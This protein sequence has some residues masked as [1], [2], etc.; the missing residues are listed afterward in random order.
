MHNQK[1]KN[2]QA[3]D[4]YRMNKSTAKGIDMIE[5][6]HVKPK[7]ITSDMKLFKEVKEGKVISTFFNRIEILDGSELEVIRL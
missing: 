7:N 4:V 6:N 5:K 2:E 3:K 1:Y